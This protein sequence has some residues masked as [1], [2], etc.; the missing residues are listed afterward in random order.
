MR[1][2]FLLTLMAATFAACG[3]IT[4]G[5]LEGE[6]DVKHYIEAKSTQTNGAYS[7]M[8]TTH[9]GN[10]L[11]VTEPGLPAERYLILEHSF[12]FKKDGTWTSRKVTQKKGFDVI[13]FFEFKEVIVLTDKGTWS[14]VKNKPEEAKGKDNMIFMT[15]QSGHKSTEIVSIEEG[16]DFSFS[17][18][19]DITYDENL[20]V[21]Y[22]NVNDATNKKMTLKS[23]ETKDNV[24]PDHGTINK[25]RLVEMKMEVKK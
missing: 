6:W 16:Y 20:D 4:K 15:Y 14:F 9:N 22:F 8:T 10:N 1:K 7:V 25:L 18:E 3:K 19:E 24:D 12:D 11:S 2:I 13:D 21:I 17:S 5:K 23:K